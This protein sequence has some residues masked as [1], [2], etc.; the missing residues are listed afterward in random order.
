MASMSDAAYQRALAG[1]FGLP[2]E[3]EA[4][5]PATDATIARLRER[6]ATLRAELAALRQRQAARA[7]QL[8][9]V[10]ADAERIAAAHRAQL[11][12]LQRERGT[13]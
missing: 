12:A 11:A 9:A 8:R 6:E 3:P 4:L 7:A 13:R 10:A 1:T 5:T 2:S